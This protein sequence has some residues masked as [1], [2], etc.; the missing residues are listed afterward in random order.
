MGKKILSNVWLVSGNDLH[1]LGSCPVNDIDLNL[2]I[3]IL[4]CVRLGFDSGTLWVWGNF[5]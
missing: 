5:R 4:P 2:T 1:C 3:N